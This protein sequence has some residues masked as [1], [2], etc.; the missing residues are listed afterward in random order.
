MAAADD[1]DFS[2]DIAFK[3][4]GVK[5]SYQFPEDLDGP[6]KRFDPR[7]NLCGKTVYKAEMVTYEQIPYHKNCFKCRRCK[8]KLTPAEANP[9]GE[10]S[11]LC[12]VHYSQ[13]ISGGQVSGDVASAD[14]YVAPAQGP[15]LV[16][17][18]VAEADVDMSDGL[19]WRKAGVKQ[20]YRYPEDTDGRP[21][22]RCQKCG[23]K[24]YQAETVTYERI[25]YH[26]N[27]F[28]CLQCKKKLTPAE[29]NPFGEAEFLCNPHYQQIALGRSGKHASGEVVSAD[30][31][32]VQAT[33]P[34][35]ISGRSS[36]NKVDETAIRSGLEWRKAGVKQAYKY[37]ECNDG[38]PDPFCNKCGKKTYKAETVTYERIPYHKNCFR[39][40]Q[41]N[42]KLTT[43]EANPFGEDSYLC[44]THFQQIALGRTGVG[45]ESAVNADS[46]VA[47]VAGPSTVGGGRK[48][49]RTRT[50]YKPK[51]KGKK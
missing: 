20:N 18:S 34:S 40:V 51:K 44:N 50:S 33:G 14:T 36:E 26:K 19:A 46:A 16:T 47:D 31:A 17:G 10:N 39:C 15:S 24:S 41:C 8:K 32:D 6:D 5:Q 22:P 2:A 37:P 43:A 38:R 28:K 25:P 21:D 11:Y 29:A 48:K 23:K 27:C 7:C 1:D 13:V 30:S 9:F 35:L 3:K 49:G 12:N 42:K 4:S 45:A